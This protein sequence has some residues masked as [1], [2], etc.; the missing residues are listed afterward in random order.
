MFG[1]YLCVCVWVL[2]LFCIIYFIIYVPDTHMAL[3]S[4]MD[5]KPR[6]PALIATKD[7]YHFHLYK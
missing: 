3:H 5:R 7:S 1:I 2:F 4:I 6:L